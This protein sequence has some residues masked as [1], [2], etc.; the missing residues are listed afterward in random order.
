[1]KYSRTLLGA[2]VV[3]KETGQPG[4]VEKIHPPS[5][6]VRFADN[7]IRLKYPDELK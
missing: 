5:V 7:T 2:K 4:V 3:D 1:M 6:T